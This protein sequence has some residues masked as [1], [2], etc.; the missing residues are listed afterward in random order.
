MAF[1]GNPVLGTLNSYTTSTW[2]TLFNASSGATLITRVVIAVGA[3]NINFQM[4]IT[5]SAATSIAIIQPEIGINSSTAVVWDDPIV[6]GSGDLLQ[7]WADAS[8]ANFSAHGA[9]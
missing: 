3:N 6:L 2:T 8:G 9:Q 7:V 5:N 1:G 4:Q